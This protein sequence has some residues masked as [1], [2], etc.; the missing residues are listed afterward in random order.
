MEALVANSATFHTKTAFSQVLCVAILDNLSTCSS[1]RDSVWGSM[2]DF[3]TRC[4]KKF[5]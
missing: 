2:I 5:K 1:D 4:G 3:S